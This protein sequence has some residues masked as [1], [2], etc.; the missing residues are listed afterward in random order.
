MSHLKGPRFHL[1]T[2]SNVSNVFAL[3][4]LPDRSDVIGL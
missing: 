2:E 1:T 4:R 3:S